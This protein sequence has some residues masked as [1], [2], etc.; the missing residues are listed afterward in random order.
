MFRH[1]LPSGARAGSTNVRRGER[2]VQAV[3]FWTA[4]VLPLSYLPLLFVGSS[5]FATIPLIGKLV[6]LNVLALLVG[7]GYRSDSTETD[8]G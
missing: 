8:E 7:H 1:P 2:F 4:A 3:A 5:R 6:S